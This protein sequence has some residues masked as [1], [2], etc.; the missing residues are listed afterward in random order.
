[1]KGGLRVALLLPR[2][3]PPREELWPASTSR[4]FKRKQ[5]PGASPGGLKEQTAWETTPG[6]APVTGCWRDGVGRG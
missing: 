5:R 2:S 4:P 1:M 3:P 6:T